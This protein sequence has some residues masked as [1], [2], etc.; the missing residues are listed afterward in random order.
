MQ[1]IS[2]SWHCGRNTRRGPSH[3][4]T[5]NLLCLAALFLFA[6]MPSTGWAQTRVSVNSAQSLR[7]ALERDG[8][9]DITITGDFVL[10]NGHT[11]TKPN[12]DPIDYNSVYL[13]A[14]GKKT[15]N[16]Q[17]S[18]GGNYKITRGSYENN[19]IV[20]DNGAW[21]V[22]ENLILDGDNQPNYASMVVAPPKIKKKINN[23]DH[24]DAVNAKLEMR[25]C[26]I[27]NC[28]QTIVTQETLNSFTVQQTSALNGYNYTFAASGNSGGAGV[29][30]A[31]GKAM[32]G[33]IDN[34]ITI[35]NCYFLNNQI[36][37]GANTTLE[38]GGALALA[39][40]FACGG[41]I[42]GCKFQQNY[43][44]NYGGAIWFAP[45]LKTSNG[46][47][48]FLGTTVVGGSVDKK[49]WSEE[50]GGGIAV[51]GGRV[52]FNEEVDIQ[53]N[54]TEGDGGGIFISGGQVTFTDKV[55]ISY[56]TAKK[57]GGICQNGGTLEITSNNTPSQTIKIE[58]N[59]ATVT[60]QN[61]Q[62]NTYEGG[63]G[64][65]VM[66]GTTTNTTPITTFT[67]TESNPIQ[68]INNKATNAY[69]GGILVH[70]AAPTFT[71]CNIGSSGNGNSAARRGGGIYL[72]STESPYVASFTNC[73]IDYNYTTN[74]D[75][76]GGGVYNYGEMAVYA[77]TFTNCY[78]RYNGENETNKTKNGGGVYLYGSTRLNNC[79]IS[80]NK[81][82]GDGGG[83]YMY[84]GYATLS[85]GCHVND[86]TA[87]Q[88]GGIYYKNGSFE[89]TN[90]VYNNTATTNGGGVFVEVT[91]D[92]TLS[93]LVIGSNVPA[94]NA[95]KGN[96]AQQGGGVYTYSTSDG[97]KLLT[98]NNCKIVYNQN[99][100]DG[101][102]RI[103][104][105]GG[106][107]MANENSS[108]FSFSHTVELTGGTLID[109]NKAVNGGGV[110]LTN[111]G[112]LTLELINT[113]LSNNIA[114]NNG[115]GIYNDK[116]T[117]TSEN[118]NDGT[119]TF[120]G[121]STEV[122]DGGGIYNNENGKVKLT[123]TNQH[124]FTEN[125]AARSGGG[126]YN[127]GTSTC[128]LKNCQIGQSGK[129][130]VAAT[131]GGGIYVENGATTTLLPGDIT[132]EDNRAS[133]NGGGIFNAGTVTQAGGCTLTFDHNISENNNGGGVFHIGKPLTLTNAIFKNNLA[134]MNGGGVYHSG[135]SLTLTATFTNNTATTGNGGGIY[136][137]NTCTLNNCTIGEANKPNKAPNGN[138][139]GIYMN[140]EEL[141]INGGSVSYN[142]ATNNGGGIYLEQKNTF[143]NN[144]CRIQKNEAT[145]GN[146][147]GIYLE[148]KE[149]G[150]LQPGSY[151]FSALTVIGSDNDTIGTLDISTGE[152]KK[153][154]EVL[155]ENVEIG[156]YQSGFRYDIYP[157]DNPI[158]NLNVRVEA[159]TIDRFMVYCDK[160][161]SSA[162]HTDGYKFILRFKQTD[163]G[164]VYYLDLEFGISY[165]EY[166]GY[167][168]QEYYYYF[169]GPKE[170]PAATDATTLTLNGSTVGGAGMGNTAGTF[171]GGVYISSGAIMGVSGAVKVKGNT[172][173][174]STNDYPY[175][176][177]SLED[178]V[179]LQS[180]NWTQANNTNI[181]AGGNIGKI[182]VHGDITGSYIGI[183]E[184]QIA[185]GPDNDVSNTDR[186]HNYEGDI[187]RQFTINYGTFYNAK[188]ATEIFFSNDKIL[189]IKRLYPG[190]NSLGENVTSTTNLL[191]V[192]L[193]LDVKAWYVAGIWDDGNG[194]APRYKWGRDD[195]LY[196]RFPD[197][198]LRT[199]TGPEGVFARGYNP[200][201]DHIFVVRAIS[202]E[203]EA[204]VR[205]TNNEVVIRYPNDWNQNDFKVDDDDNSIQSIPNTEGSLE[206]TLHRYPG[207]HRL[208]SAFVTATGEYVYDSK[209]SNSGGENGA[210]P[211]AQAAGGT[212]TANSSLKPGAN[213]GPL[214]QMDASNITTL[215]DVHMDG[216]AEFDHVENTSHNPQGFYI[217]P[218]SALLAV[219]DVTYS[220][221]NT[222]TGTITLKETCEL[223]WN[224]NKYGSDN[225]KEL[226]TDTDA[227][228]KREQRT[229]GAVFCAG[230]LVC[231]GTVIERNTCIDTT[232]TTTNGRGGGIY[233][234]PGGSVT[235]DGCIVGSEGDA[236][237]D[238]TNKNM[239]QYGGGIYIDN[240][241]YNDNNTPEN[242][243]DDIPEKSGVVI[244]TGQN[245]IQHNE[246]TVK[247]GGVYKLGRLKIQDGTT[248]EVDKPL[249]ITK[250]NIVSG[251]DENI[252]YTLNNV[253]IPIESADDQTILITGALNC[254]SSVGVTKTKKW[255]GDIGYGTQGE[256]TYK[257]DKYFE[258]VNTPI[259][260]VDSWEDD[261]NDPSTPSVLANET[262]AEDAFYKRIFFDDKGYYRV[263]SFDFYNY[264]DGEDYSDQKD[265]F[266]ETW[267][268]YANNGTDHV[269][270]DNNNKLV[271]KAK[272]PQGF[273]YFAKQV[274]D[275]EDYS[276]VDLCQTT[277]IDLDGHH[278]EPIGYTFCGGCGGQPHRPFAGTY[279]GN[280][281]FILNAI[282]ILPE[283]EMGLFGNVTG[284]VK[285]TFA[286]G[287]LFSNT[288]DHTS[289]SDNHGS[290]SLGAI[291]G[292]TTGTID[293]CEAAGFTLKGYATATGATV[294]A[295]GIAGNV[296]NGEVRNSF[297]S[298]ITF[299][300]S[301]TNA[302]GLAGNI[303]SGGAVKNCYSKAAIPAVDNCNNGA[304]VG[305]NE[306]TLSNAY[307]SATT[308]AIVGSGTQGTNVYSAGATGA[309]AT[310][311]API[312]ADHLGYMCIDNGV[313]IT[314]TNGLTEGKD[315]FNFKNASGNEVNLIPL[316]RLLNLN[317]SDNYTTYAEWARP[318]LAYYNSSFNGIERPINGDLPLLMLNNYDGSTHIGQGGFRSVGTYGGGGDVLQ[319]GGP[320]RDGNGLD[321]ALTRPKVTGFTGNDYLFVYGDV[322]VAPAAELNA[323]TQ[324][325]VS[326]YEHAA[327]SRAGT[328]AGFTQTYVG[329]TFDNSGKVSGSA[330]NGINY[331]DNGPSLPRN[332]H[333]LST[334]LTNAPLGFRYGD[335]DEDNEKTY[336]E[337][338]NYN[339]DNCYNNPWGGEN[340]SNTPNTP[341]DREFSWLGNSNYA[342]G[343]TRYWMHGWNNSRVAGTHDNSSYPA[344]TWKDGYFPSKVN[345]SAIQFGAQLFI[346]FENNN[347][348]N[349]YVNG[350]HRYPYGMDF[351]SWYEPK[352]HY[353]NFK[354]NGPNHW[355]S[356]APHVHLDYTPEEASNNS[357]ATAFGQNVNETTLLDGK[358]Y[359]ASIHIP[360]FLQTSGSLG[361]S[362]KTIKVTYNENDLDLCE[363]WNLVGNP[364]HA[365]L[366]FNAFSSANS[367]VGNQYVVYNAD[368]F[369]RPG[370]GNYGD[371]F[372]YYVVGGSQNGAYAGQY[373]HPHQGFFVKVGSSTTLNFAE[374]QTVLR[375]QIGTSGS[376]RDDSRPA[377]PLVNLFLTSD[378]GC[379]DVCVVE[380]NRP[381]WGGAT[382]LRDMY[383]GNGLF[384]AAHDNG[385]YAALFATPEAE[386]IP[387]K[388][389][390]KDEAGD[391]YTIHWNTQNGDFHKLYL[392]DNITGVQYDMLRNSSYSF[393]G[394]K[395]DYWTR[396]Y[397]TFEVTGLDEEQDDEDDDASTGSAST[398]FAFFDGSQWVVTN[399]GHG[400]A[401]LDLIDLQ[402]RVLHSTTLAE[403]QARIGLPDVAKGMYL[404]RMTNQNGM[405]VQKIVVR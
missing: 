164:V 139:G 199:L 338:E 159:H 290:A 225:S 154:T 277:T 390:A 329:V 367:A 296:G 44:R 171:G 148:S 14:A 266:I 56:N 236:G 237:N 124:I 79:T 201:T 29:H 65:L 183:T 303:A 103:T 293:G 291:V 294:A 9:V 345:T 218:K 190:L 269:E 306:G 254:G 368:G 89:N 256:H 55:N 253:H 362:T 23:V 108:I 180:L 31:P 292:N 353:I 379:S 402:G 98:I 285:H 33:N 342:T 365:Y 205:K 257:N 179:C 392:V 6:L 88:G 343:H 197:I 100:S 165:E 39:G 82:T 120:H 385:N 214:V 388:F 208:S 305:N 211:S 281:H 219:E 372:S 132:F 63:G 399:D 280:G 265:Y 264:G 131:A 286:V 84:S 202:I 322:N 391:T 200:H 58:N 50:C 401:T 94:A 149:G 113:R 161:G 115:G 282:S 382:K 30:F 403:G 228:F 344:S 72:A 129:G 223:L 125:I 239:A 128:S 302:G 222:N 204:K 323:F 191:E 18:S 143:V 245:A 25:N 371:G 288:H 249:H 52:I 69:G 150:G 42:K 203:E 332:W 373:L 109:N 74:A 36:T 369:G 339:N 337:G 76:E 389:E 60:P 10:N 279:N 24:E 11:A 43:A 331:I 210:V 248:N 347:G 317:N 247:G 308:G 122:E 352:Y 229:G 152:I 268:S 188:N 246:A 189:D 235:L 8:D 185:I 138:G 252:T 278:W 117:V 71:F 67:G 298:G 184:E 270:L 289:A 376:Y 12:A 78:I 51:E 405:F 34:K 283:K 142:T 174:R 64:V 126:I 167:E 374:S 398:T 209:T 70:R 136:T 187:H 193:G 299:A 383:S 59:T 26:T 221:N 4:L 106:L 178:D 326:I 155:A 176:K 350:N 7:V 357:D 336:I 177:G 363:G 107:C 41:T 356:N 158:Y 349:E 38:N 335:D 216:L 251:T 255:A 77:N 137:E 93:G 46:S 260:K 114:T 182:Y 160:V 340:G 15:I 85:N 232:N 272:S 123:G 230:T 275:G 151:T 381:E 192:T 163:G 259:A 16:G 262:W 273:A 153:S 90:Y 319:Y 95:D 133:G 170:I 328:L 258:E 271:K 112:T 295:G 119:I 359:M 1:H 175:L 27:Q 141:T 81:A 194:N 320:D 321:A 301:I 212:P 307:T 68:I 5:T 66:G 134:T 37:E 360:T 318:A 111:I 54:T 297:T 32:S 386:R 244:L 198:P 226:D 351:Y 61:T 2:P 62:Y 145:N 330:T 241:P 234:K 267:R 207:G 102:S 215:Y 48:Q 105:G 396:F 47:F 324:A 17:K 80:N 40:E 370:N 346:P 20:L 312:G 348:S 358:G 53:Y 333:M 19:S 354:R 73:N 49:N 196:G 393:S 213:I 387:L 57:G 156:C 313:A 217:S 240:I 121:N 263:W 101:V 310:Y 311:T 233:V 334:P 168:G 172:T 309:T 397:I 404:M 315:Y 169:D 13:V 87:N 3:R 83:L 380:F 314:N 238:E 162:W 97:N 140:G 146:G 22:I 378:K 327:I 91:A 375:S 325:K 21:L 166:E 195:P 147:G 250:N 400:T 92:R 287:N 130:N 96:K 304:L 118:N 384:Y 231:E 99:Q 220:N 261:D 135:E 361:G 300:G 341:S 206:V 28:K 186:L 274:N 284:T 144:N 181:G 364:F 316:F 157:P 110:Y 75:S 395:D 224:N 243:S 355:H 366:D 377:Y 242:P 227:K 104:S 116:Q 86:N 127:G 394:K 276:G 173:K 35:E 45:S